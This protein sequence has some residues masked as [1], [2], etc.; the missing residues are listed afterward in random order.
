MAAPTVRGLCDR[1]DP[2]LRPAPGFDAPPTPISA[3]HISD[4]L[5]PTEFLSGGELLL[6]TG[7]GLPKSLMGCQRYVRRLVDAGVAALAFG[8]GPVYDDLP[9]PLVTACREGGLCLLVVPAPTPFLVITTAYW[10]DLGRSA[11]RQLTDVLATQQRLVDAAATTAPMAGVLRTLVRALSG[12]AAVL[13]EDGQVQEVWPHAAV[14]EAESVRTELDRLRV[15]G[16]RSAA[17]L[18]V[19]D[20]HVSVYPLAVEETVHGYLAF[21]GDAPLRGTDRRLLLTACALLSIALVRRRTTAL[22]SAAALASVPLLLDLG[23]PEAA[24]RL[25]ARLDA[26]PLG[27]R[28]RLL[29]VTGGTEDDVRRWCPTAIACPVDEDRAWFVLP[30]DPPPLEA[31]RAAL[32]RRTPSARLQMSPAVELADVP[33]VRAGLFADASGVADLDAVLA[34]LRGRP[35]LLATLVAYLRHRGQVDPAA[36]ALGI[37]RNTFRQRMERLRE[38]AAVDLDDVDVAAPLWLA[39]RARGLVGAHGE[40]GTSDH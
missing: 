40:S 39:L 10:S 4:L 16:V 19:G 25:A 35:D 37:H 32:T 36:R 33:G 24:V 34:R 38:V 31:L 2:Q 21:G 29:A 1:L 22:G 5:D 13:D 9:A 17:S 26:P 8:L 23:L 7:L 3:V 28:V 11:E 6:T 12:W 20:A 14:D 30:P 18:L 27:S 15:A